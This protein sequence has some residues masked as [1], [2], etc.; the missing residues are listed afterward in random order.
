[1]LH[2]ICRGKG[3]SLCQILHYF[4]PCLY[5][6]IQHIQSVFRILKKEYFYHIETTVKGRLYVTARGWEDLSQ[7]LYLYEEEKLPVSE[8][9]IGQYI[10]NDKI[11]KEFGA[12]YDLYQKACICLSSI[13]SP[14]S[15]SFTALKGAI[16]S[17]R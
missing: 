6:F 1:M 16:I 13:S 4:F 3:T 9:L 10:R 15:A 5:L 2:F 8:A 12:Y 7:I 11:V 17:C 14:S